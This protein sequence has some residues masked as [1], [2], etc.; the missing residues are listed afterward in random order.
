MNDNV[1]WPWW[2]GLIIVCLVILVI[3]YATAWAAGRE[4]RDE[5]RR[6]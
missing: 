2:L 1:S 6:R 4:E 5:R 3:A